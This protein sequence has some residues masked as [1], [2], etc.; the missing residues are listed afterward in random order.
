[1]HSSRN[2]NEYRFNNYLK[3]FCT[4][5]V[6]HVT[7]YDTSL[8]FIKCRKITTSS[9]SQLWNTDFLWDAKVSNIHPELVVCFWPLVSWKV[10]KLDT[11]PWSKSNLLSSY[12]RILARRAG[13]HSPGTAE[14]PAAHKWKRLQNPGQ[15]AG[16]VGCQEPRASPAD[17]WDLR[18]LLKLS[19]RRQ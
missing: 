7:K 17:T 5:R 9:V 11:F 4:L 3:N 8:Y 2:K 10:Q 12:A 6:S 1:M 18:S 13:A 19:T 16:C 15:M 14:E